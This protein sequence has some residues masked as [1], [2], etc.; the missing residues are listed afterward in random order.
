MQTTTLKVKAIPSSGTSVTVYMSTWHNFSKDLNFNHTAIDN[1]AWCGQIGKPREKSQ[2]Q[3]KTLAV[4][5]HTCDRKIVFIILTV[6]LLQRVSKIEL[7]QD[8]SHNCTALYSVTS[9]ISGAC[10]RIVY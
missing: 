5:H 8:D 3:N 7:L 4:G 10:Y 2:D 6:I 9:P 1:C